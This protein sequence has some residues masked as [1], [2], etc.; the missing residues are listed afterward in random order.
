MKLLVLLTVVMMIGV[1]GTFS[2]GSCPKVELQED[3]DISRYTGTWYE[4]IRSKDMPYEKGTC[5]RAQYGLNGD[6]TVSVVNSEARDNKWNSVNGYAY[7]DKKAPSQCHVKFSR[8]A[9]AGDYK[10]VKTDYKNYSLVFSCF[11][12]GVAHWKWVWVLARQPNF[13]FAQFVP[14]IESFGIPSSKLYYT[15][16]DNCPSMNEV[17]LE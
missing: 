9:P 13:D 16:Q 3:F 5:S 4:A 12:I 7:C 17:D 15:P 11:S 6:G 2:W 8:F 14:E 1:E 10:V